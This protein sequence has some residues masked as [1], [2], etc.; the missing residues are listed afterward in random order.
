[1]VASS[2]QDESRGAEIIIVAWVFTGIAI[3]VAAL[4]FFVK[5]RISK[6]LGWD[7]FFILLSMATGIAASIF[8]SYPVCLGLGKHTAAVLAEPGGSGKVL[9]ATKI[10]MIGY[11]FNILAFTLPNVAIAILVN[12]LLDPRLWRTRL[13]YSMAALQ[14][15]LALI[16]CI[17]VYVQCT[18]I[19]KLW[20]PSLPGHCW[21]PSIL[22]DIT[23]FMTAYTIMTDIALAAMPITAKETLEK[24]EIL[25]SAS[26]NDELKL[27]ELHK[28]VEQLRIMVEFSTV[29]PNIQSQ[30]KLLLCTEE[31]VFRTIAKERILNSLSFEAMDRRENMVAETHSNTYAW[32][33]EDD[34]TIE[35]ASLLDETR[36]E[37][38]E[39]SEKSSRH[40]IED[41][42]FRARTKLSA[43]LTA[44]HTSDIFHLSGKLGSGKSTLMKSIIESPR[45]FERLEEW[46]DGRKL[47]IAKFYFWNAGSEYERSLRGL[48]RSL[49]H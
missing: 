43:W 10:Q 49:L 45:T 19:E 18:P 40:T 5:A 7:D 44:K 48:Y 4:R 35:E 3:V 22:N 13:L 46:A 34:Q 37:R 9:L 39:N 1:M 33:V 2:K 26:K 25:I 15:V 41:E 28:Q 16:P 38:S 29:S 12:R 27:A 23:Y 8:A 6:E 14:V 47:T 36:S 30:L 32:V 11:P 31:E 21:D 42:K 20:N 24:L 17:I